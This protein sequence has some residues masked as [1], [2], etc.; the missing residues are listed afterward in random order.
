MIAVR[1]GADLVCCASSGSAPP[2]GTKMDSASGLCGECLISGRMVRSEEFD[3]S[4]RVEIPSDGSHSCSAIIMPLPHGSG[5]LGVFS[6][7]ALGNEH[8][9]A[10]G[11][12]ATLA[13]LIGVEE[14][15]RS[16]DLGQAQVALQR[17]EREPTPVENVSRPG[18]VPNRDGVDD[19]LAR[20]QEIQRLA[21]TT[22]H[23]GKSKE[24]AARPSVR[25]KLCNIAVLVFLIAIGWVGALAFSLRRSHKPASVVH[26]APPSHPEITVKTFRCAC[27]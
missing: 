6:D 17:F 1:E 4:S 2:I 5:I 24:V 15:K 11:T 21:L 14:K 27:R 12:A 9:T 25:L 18:A 13:G 3:R 26:V 22:S 16:A 20:V 8:L 7:S 10:L 23:Q 19:L